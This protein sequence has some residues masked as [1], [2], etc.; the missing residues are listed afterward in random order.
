VARNTL[1][2]RDSIDGV[3]AFW[4]GI[5][6]GTVDSIK[7]A[8]TSNRLRKIFFENGLIWSQVSDWDYLDYGAYMKDHDLFDP[9]RIAAVLVL[10][11][12][13]NKESRHNHIGK[14]ASFPIDP[15]KLNYANGRT[16]HAF[17]CLIEGMRPTPGMGE[18]EGHW[19]VPSENKKKP[20]VRPHHIGLDLRCD[21]D[22]M[23]KGFRPCFAM[24]LVW[25]Y[26]RL[27]CPIDMEALT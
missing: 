18:E 24:Y 20:D 11:L 17:N 5:S 10:R 22:A 3:Y 21:C 2:V 7:K 8:R 4:N 9:E 14:D 1:I 6:T 27:I 16:I 15:Q 26:Q 12:K 13:A 23:T 19:Y 25:L